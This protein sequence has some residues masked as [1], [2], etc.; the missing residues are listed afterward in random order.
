MPSGAGQPGGR[1]DQAGGEQGD[2][3][4]KVGKTAKA[5]PLLRAEDK[6]RIMDQ[7]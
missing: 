4:P 7:V 6:H 3:P 1:H 5:Q 2:E